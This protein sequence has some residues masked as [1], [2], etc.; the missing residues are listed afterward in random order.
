MAQVAI[1][2]PALERERTGGDVGGVGRD[3][4]GRGVR[5]FDRRVR[6]FERQKEN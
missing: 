6:L 2:P 4:A 3:V 5:I 1:S